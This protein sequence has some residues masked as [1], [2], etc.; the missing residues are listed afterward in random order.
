MVES[1]VDFFGR[2][3]AEWLA[4]ADNEARRDAIALAEIIQ[5][6]KHGFGLEGEQ[7]QDYLRR[8]V[9]YLLE[10][11]AHPVV[12]SDRKNV[13]WEIASEFCGEVSL[14]ISK[15]IEHWEQSGSDDAYFVWFSH[16]AS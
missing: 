12:S 8:V 3:Q 6:A 16:N 1:K 14:V 4:V 2:S 7:L 9:L 13:S 10:S 15:I 11:G 5:Q